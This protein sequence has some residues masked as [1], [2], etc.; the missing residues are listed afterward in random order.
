MNRLYIL[1]LVIAGIGF[2]ACSDDLP[3]DETQQSPVNSDASKFW[4]SHMRTAAENRVMYRHHAL[5]FSYRAVTGSKCNLGDVMCQVLNMDYI[6]ENG[7]YGEEIRNEVTDTIS[8]IRGLTDYVHQVNWHSDMSANLILFQNSAAKDGFVIEKVDEETLIFNQVIGLS[9]RKRSVD[10]TGLLDEDGIPGEVT[11]NPDEVLSENFR[12]ALRKLEAASPNNYAVVDSFINI[13]GTHVVTGVSAGGSFDLSVRTSSRNVKTFFQEREFKEN[14]A[15]F[16]IKWESIES[17]QHSTIY[18]NIFNTAELKLTVKGGDA[19]LFDGLVADPSYDNLQ[20]NMENYNNWISSI[21]K[22]GGNEWDERSEL[23]DM[24][25]T[26]IWEFIP[27]KDIARRVQV[28]IMASAN[29]M[30]KIYGE[31][32]FVNASITIPGPDVRYDIYPKDMNS[33]YQGSVCHV[34]TGDNQSVPSRIVAVSY[35]EWVPEAEGDE[36]LIVTYP[37]YENR[38]QLT[39]GIGR[40]I[41]DNGWYEVKWLYDRFQVTKMETESDV[42]YLAKGKLFPKK[43]EWVDDSRNTRYMPDYEW[44]GSLDTNGNLNTGT[45]PYMVRKF[46]DK[47]YLTDVEEMAPGTR[48]DNLPGWTYYDGSQEMLTEFYVSKYPDAET[49]LKPVFR[50]AGLGYGTTRRMMRNGIYYYK[51][52]PKEVIR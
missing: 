35:L 45:K 16:F 28:R 44:P 51:I 43:P 1:L 7:L 18:K 9:T 23:I 48:F 2:P 6:K 52:I 36:W 33:W 24:E 3:L 37:V 4:Y 38:I 5:G 34:I 11:E 17:S 20:A 30:R 27:D 21:E 8:V 46:L 39:E 32:N 26:P 10:L 29:E 49:V 13:F 12:Y 40:S 25:V 19:S 41:K 15:K 31:R 22:A 42:F 50:Q 14:S 47:F